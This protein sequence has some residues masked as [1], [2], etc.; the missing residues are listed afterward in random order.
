MNVK[1]S[2]RGAAVSAD[3]LN[4][5]FERTF[6][7]TAPTAMGK[8]AGATNLCSVSDVVRMHGGRVFANCNAAQG[9]TFWFTLPALAAGGEEINHE[10]AVNFG[11]RRR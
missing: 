3:A 2:C 1:I 4:S 7:V 9:V 8:D 10:Q 11:S 5:I 6:S